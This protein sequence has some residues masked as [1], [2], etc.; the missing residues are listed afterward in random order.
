M[1]ACY[2]DAQLA[3]LNINGEG[4]KAGIDLIITIGRLEKE[5]DHHE[6]P[7]TWGGP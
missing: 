3:E 1:W 4:V 6:I 7:T 2:S 5:K